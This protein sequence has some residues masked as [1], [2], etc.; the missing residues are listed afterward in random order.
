MSTDGGAATSSSPTVLLVSSFVVVPKLV[1]LSAPGGRTGGS[2]GSGDYS[3]GS[4]SHILCIVP[5]RLRAP[6]FS[7]SSSRA[8]GDGIDA[9][10]TVVFFVLF[11]DDARGTLDMSSFMRFAR[12]GAANGLMGSMDIVVLLQTICYQTSSSSSSS[13]LPSF[14]KLYDR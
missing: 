11:D 7:S 8:S 5:P 6:I 13:L 9:A 12:R 10:T 2:F 4:C 1:T 14:E 3:D